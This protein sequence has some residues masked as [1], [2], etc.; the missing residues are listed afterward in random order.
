M[1]DVRNRSRSPWKRFL[2]IWAAA[3]LLLGAIGCIVLYRYLG[4]Y[5]LT[6]PE[7][8]L[9]A[10]LE[11]TNA[12]EL[13]REAKEHVSLS[14]TEFEDPG[15][16]YSSYL[17]TVDTGRTLSYRS[18]AKRSGR[19]QLTY[20]VYAG[21]NAL[22]SLILT[23]EGSSPGFGRHIWKVTGVES[24]PITE[25]L[26]S[27]HLVVDTIPGTELKLNGKALT[28]SY[29][30][31]RDIAIPDLSKL[32][33]GL[34]PLPTF[35]RYEIGPLYGEVNL[36]NAA[37][38]TLSPSGDSGGSTLYYQASS[39]SE[40]LT[41]RAPESV[42]VFVNGVRLDTLD[43]TSSSAGILEGL[44]LYTGEGAENTCVYEFD[45]LYMPPEVTG[46]EA[47][48]TALLPVATAENSF[49]FF[50]QNDPEAEAELRPV[51]ERFFDAYMKYSSH[52]WDA[53]N[54]NNLL[55][56]IL[57]GTSLYNY[58]LNS[59]DAMYWA[60]KTS[61]EYKDL[62]YD[63]FHRVSDYCFTCTVVYS[64][65]MTATSWYEQYSY[66]LENAY[67]LAFISTLGNW[68]AVSMNVIAE[69]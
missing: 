6:R 55:T 46:I 1:D 65:D 38:R 13:I 10:Y 54:Y 18:D 61:T 39:G 67:E 49:T 2:L 8:V 4:V 9:D 25:L 34:D 53:S 16:L 5:E 47:D 24:A 26:P 44:E 58:V 66:S 43:I 62:R 31:E 14:L 41:I 19:N 57:Y 36:T 59:T 3:L 52:S 33:A 28:E 69:S 42:Q 35:D 30:T 23:P 20:V 22:C 45:G 64:A 68:Y 12:G 63:N 15:E 32:E 50:H 60:S 48:G 40:R 37:G 27:L 56:K 7:P 21:P 51:A 11:N 17:E 29:L